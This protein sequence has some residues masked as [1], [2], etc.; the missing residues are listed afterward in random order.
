MGIKTRIKRIIA[1]LL[2]FCIVLGGIPVTGGITAY[3]LP[4]IDNSQIANGH[5][6]NTIWASLS[7]GARFDLVGIK[8]S[9]VYD[10]QTSNSQVL[11]TVF[12]FGGY[13]TYMNDSALNS[14]Q[15]T[16]VP[17]SGAYNGGVME[18][19]SN[20]AKFPNM[21]VS[22]KTNT[23]PDG[24]YVF[25]DY[26]IYNKNTTSKTMYIGTTADVQIGDDDGANLSRT[27][28]TR[29]GFYMVNGK[30]G[31]DAMATFE[32]ITNDPALRIYGEEWGVKRWIGA[33]SSGYNCNHLITAPDEFEST[34]PANQGYQYYTFK[35][36][37]N[38]FNS[39][40][41][42]KTNAMG[43]ASAYLDSAFAY[44]WKVE[45][46][47]YEIARR[48]VAYTVR[49]TS[50][51]V[52]SDRG[53][54]STS[55]DGSYLNPFATIDYAMSKLNGKRGYIY[56]MDYDPINGSINV[57]SGAGTDITILSSNF[58]ENGET[59]S[60]IVELERGTNPT[61]PMFHVSSNNSK[62]RVNHITINGNGVVS[63][64]PLVK[65][66]AGELYINAETT[67][68]GNKITNPASGS[69]LDVT[70]SASLI[71]NSG[72]VSN[73]ISNGSGAVNFNSTGEISVLND[74][75]ITDNT[76]TAG[77]KANVFLSAGKYITVEG[78]LGTSRIGVTSEQIPEASVGE[79]TTAGQEVVI[80]VPSADYSGSLSSCPF[81]DNFLADADSGNGAGIYAT[82]G[83]SS[84]SNSRNTVLKRNGYAVSF[85][86]RDS[87]SGGTVTGAP[88]TP[89][90]SLASGDGVVIPPPSAISGYELSGIIIE[91]GTGST[92]TA[93]ETAGDTFGK[94]TGTMPGQDVMV[95]YEYTRINASIAFVVNGGTPQPEILT[96][97]AGNSVNALLPNVTRYGYVFKGWS[98][99]N[100]QSG[101][102]Y[103][104]SLPAVYPE[105]P[106]TYYAIWES[107]P[108]VKFDYTVDYTN[109]NGSIVFQTTTTENTYSVEA[110]IQS[111]KKNIHGYL[112]SLLDSHTSPVEYNYDGLG[113]VP[114]GNFNGATGQFTGKMPGQDAA[115]KYA[116]KVDRNNPDAR[117]S[118]TVRYVTENGTVIHEPGV[119]PYYP[120][121][122]ISTA[123]LDLYGYQ[124][125][126][127]RITAG[128][129]PDDADGNLV[130]AVQGSFGNNGSFTGV[131]PNQPV[132]ITYIYE[133]TEEGYAFAVNFLDN[134]TSDSSLKNIINPEVQQKTADTAVSAEFRELYGYT[135]ESAA[136]VPAS[137]GSFDGTHDFTGIMPNDDLTVSYRYDR[138]PSQ[139][140]RIIFKSGINGAISHG[141]GVSSDVQEQGNGTGVYEASVLKNDGTTAGQTDSYTWSTIKEKR[142]VPL[143]QADQYYRFAGWFID[144]NGNGS[145]DAGE[146]LLEEDHRFTGD[147]TVTALFEEDPEKWINIQFAA[148]EHGSLADGSISSL[149]IQYDRTWG[150]IA[151]QIP[152]YVPEVNYLVDGWYDGD[153][154]VES[155]DGL[156]NGHTYTIRF[157]PDPAVFGTDVAAPDAS[158]GLNGEGKGKITVYHTTAGYQYVIT[159]LSGKIVGVQTG[160][161]AGRV[162]FDGL[163]PG[164]RYLVYEAAG[165]VNAV[166]GNQI[167]ETAGNIS[168][169]VEV[170]TPVVETNYQILYD[171]NHEGK[172]VLVIKPA[173][174][175]SDYAVLSKEGTVIL[176]QETGSDG[177]QTVTGNPGSVTFSGL[178]YNEEYI[179]V[180]RP[181]GETGITAESR[182]PDGSA[183]T[184]DPGGALEI[185]NYIVETL[186]GRVVSVDQEEI[187]AARYEEA[188][189]GD[190]VKITADASKGAGETFLYWKITIGSVPGLTG[191][192]YERELA[193][194]MPDTNLVFTAYY[195]R[196]VASPSIAT[197]VDEVRGG[198]GNDIALDPGEIPDLE[199]ELT[200]DADRILMDQNHADVTYKVVY[201][202]NAAKATESNAVKASPEYNSD[203][204][205]AFKAAWGLNVDIERYVNG[206][207]TAMATPSD[208]EFVTY[209]QLNK[210]DVDMMD[211]QLYRITTDPDDGS[212]QAE[213]VELS[214]DP[215][216]T[217]GLFTFTAQAGTRYVL[218]YSK[219]YRLYF[220]NRIA[221]PKYQYYFK[222]RKG[223]APSD[224]YYSFEYGQVEEPE[225]LFIS[226][227]GV[228]YNYIGWSYREDR[229]N[230]FDPD[231]E[232][233][234]KTYVYAYYQD[235]Q[236]EVDHARKELEDAIKAAIDKSDDYFLTLKETGKL[237]EAIEEALEVLERT[238]PKA[239]LDE[240][241]EALEKLQEV[242]KPLDE[243]LEDRYDHYD[244]IQG[245]GSKGGSKGGGGSGSGIKAS[246]YNPS[247]SRSYTVGTNGNWEELSGTGRQW[248]FVLNGGIRL[249]GMWA[250]L[251]YAS[252]DVS[253]NGWYH[254]NANGIMDYGWFRDEKLDWYYCNT[255][256]DGWFGKMKTGWHYD[257]E[258][259]RWYYLD[260]ETGMMAKGW[261]NING[262]WYYFTEQNSMETYH[263]DPATEKW[264]YKNNEGRPL[265]SMYISEMTPDGYS[266]GGDG[267]WLH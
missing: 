218:V 65:A 267:A 111:Q 149:H 137:G 263:Y 76:N 216:E 155:T 116:Y 236:K 20:H 206:R 176:T 197:V 169:P 257:K 66:S 165:T 62:L 190:K 232:I 208:A 12:S 133:A 203:H 102:E 5:N 265:G 78:D 138:V 88:D 225:D 167:G 51:Y 168:D 213:L 68:T 209:V 54:D 114:I 177:W 48:R 253:K 187:D 234:R 18:F 136:A 254:F 33:Y 103:I 159:D 163:Y 25:V 140:T 86:Y 230:E 255:E 172:T 49:P 61:G 87:S 50:Y 142:L 158:G 238:S 148:G 162:Y 69:A 35:E 55:R 63:N 237:K 7:N 118:L 135:Y 251:D 14:G 31:A 38:D 242:T 27:F 3:A 186:E 85:A 37:K 264:I 95:T 32:C 74:I 120:E 23:S 131:M 224:G 1:G 4:E 81:A 6:D 215:E 185:P 235:N 151:G 192:L 180:A 28:G 106:V 29:E 195:S 67:F 8:K 210:D 182:L 22:V 9:G 17:N 105:D 233:S 199:E 117:S 127:G 56:I 181:K 52:S 134:G 92:L 156:K 128:D 200:T 214:E 248:V 229:L 170:L 121:D 247:R 150:D 39:S 73:N 141:S 107:D 252:G 189:K 53:A 239:T 60:D 196:P 110:E 47:P 42:I 21:E 221:I 19:A 193:F 130:S 98:K 249:T 16:Y 11:Q 112:W 80:A 108:N 123:P 153:T 36:N 96:G 220:L 164:A 109:Q 75:H 161:I 40:N 146:Q 223:E 211:Y 201:T 243:V 262:K 34:Y 244:K 204:S 183:I 132:E 250:K 91:Q 258:D 94:I 160:T 145:L 101:P 64:Y 147:E 83:S 231:R 58:D 240:L 124:F 122:A 207:K 174:K 259:S 82:I 70:G 144:Q 152:G 89:S 173:D 245:S 119:T 166:V 126:S 184:T 256:A 10:Y 44:S 139:W 227:E 226:E 30:S 202:K 260:P 188:H 45:V 93:V 113:A 24:Q 125:V 115:V 13:H 129:T 246:P 198:S 175:K 26:Y 171:E 261:R 178:N 41:D 100:S 266:V 228:E 191:K 143:A 43:N 154:E 179:V 219:A 71:I 79:S 57:P 222:V 2:A 99:V 104:S 97:T 15:I 90:L 205:Q 77:E 194:D 46:R 241:L 157:Y 212:A 217:G 72:T 59:I 84:L